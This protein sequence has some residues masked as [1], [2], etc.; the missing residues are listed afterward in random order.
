MNK[1]DMIDKYDTDPKECDGGMA[2]REDTN[3]TPKTC[4]RCLCYQCSR[5]KCQQ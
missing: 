3:P 1:A 4:K 2:C 5:G